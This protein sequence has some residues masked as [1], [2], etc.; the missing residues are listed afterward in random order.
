[1][2]TTPPVRLAA[3]SAAA[4]ATLGLAGCATPVDP[5]AVPAA[6]APAPV[7]APVAVPAAP[8]AGTPAANAAG[9][10][11]RPPDPTVPRPFAEIIK[12]AT[13][14]DGFVPVWRKDEK[15]WLEITPERLGQLLLVTVNVAQSVGERGLYASQMG[16]DWLA[17]FRKVGNQFQLVAKQLAFR[18]E[19]DPA[20]RF[21]VS[22]AFSDSL[23]GSAAIVSAPHP[24]GSAEQRVIQ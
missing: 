16:P 15:V 23:I 1:M 6:A 7:A 24:E 20:S 10:A 5:K 11:A 9:A 2:F 18:G 8:A 3:V 12:D 13:R 21:A 19:R 22:Q 14:Q 17:E 4:I